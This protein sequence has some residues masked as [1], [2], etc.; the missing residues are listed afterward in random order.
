MAK[1]KPEE[2]QRLIELMFTAL[3]RDEDGGLYSGAV[4]AFD[5]VFPEIVELCAREMES[6]AYSPAAER[7]RDLKS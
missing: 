3:V 6:L 5:V 4:A 7:L 2:H 1:I